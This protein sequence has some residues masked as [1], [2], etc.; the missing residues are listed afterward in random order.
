MEPTGGPGREEKGHS[1]TTAPHNPPEC[2][3]GVSQEDQS[4]GQK[5]T[6]N[7]RGTLCMR[8]RKARWARRASKECLGTDDA[9]REVKVAELRY[10]GDSRL[11]RGWWQPHL[12]SSV[13]R[14]V[15]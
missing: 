11:R 12:S 10:P 1:V 13:W 8:G 2:R 15:S 9:P 4:L 3:G 6:E 14:A 7:S 5:C